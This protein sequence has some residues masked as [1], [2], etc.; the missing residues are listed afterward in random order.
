[1]NLRQSVPE[2]LTTR[3]NT[4]IQIAFTT[5]FAYIFIN[6]YRPFG[7]DNWYKIKDWQLLLASAVVVLAGMV[8]IILSRLI[9]FYLKRSHEITFALYIWFTAA[10]IFF[11]GLFFTSLEIWILHDERTAIALL[12]NAIQNT[13]L[14]LLIP[15]TLSILFFAWSDIKKK[16]EQ[17]VIQFRDPS[18]VFIPFR[19]EKGSLKITIKSVNVLFMESNDNYV[20]IHY[21]DGDKRKIYMI[22]NSLKQFET[23]LK[24]Y[25]IYRTHR[26]FSVNIKN[27][28]MLK[29][30]RKGFELLINSAQEDHI[31]V[32]RSY[33][34]QIME[35]M[36]IK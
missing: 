27:V 12:F 2:Y 35:L 3:K 8:V 32:S 10:E 33:E 5:I 18:E 7:Y 23:D 13:A 31:P 4:I 24:D 36:N 1:M 15:Y 28:K 9:F 11:M 20:N 14:I 34:K 19:D 6:I 16:L 26:K 29:K 22:R 17:V 30:E 25:P 21:N